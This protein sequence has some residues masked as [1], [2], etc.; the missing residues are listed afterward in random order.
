MLIDKW[1]RIPWT[2]AQLRELAAHLTDAGEAAD[3]AA[4]A[5]QELESALHELNAAA[6]KIAAD[7]GRHDDAYVGTWAVLRD[8]PDPTENRD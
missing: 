8:R 3:T 1:Q 7:L 4:V 5:Q 6:A 2:A